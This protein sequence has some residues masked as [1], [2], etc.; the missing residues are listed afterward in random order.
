[1]AQNIQIEKIVKP[2][3]I[4]LINIPFQDFESIKSQLR[5]FQDELSILYHET[6]GNIDITAKGINKY[7]TLKQLIGETSYVAFG[8]DINDYEMLQHA[9]SSFYVSSQS[10]TLSFENATIVQPH[11]KALIDSIR[12]LELESNK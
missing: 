12:T 8:N 10:A 6:E 1:M 5:D 11:S 4:I 7:T 3:K 9:T 2:I